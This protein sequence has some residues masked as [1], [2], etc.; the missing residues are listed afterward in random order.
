MICENCKK[1]HGGKYGSGR[2]CNNICARGF[3][4]KAKRGDINKKVSKTM[5][6]L[7]E[8]GLHFQPQPKNRIIKTCLECKTN[9]EDYISGKKKFC[10]KKC[11]NKSSIPCK[12]N[13]GLRKG[14][15]IG[16]KGWYKGYWCDSSWE[17]AWVIYHIE[18]KIDFERNKKGFDYVFNGKNHKYYPDFIKNNVY[19]EI[20]GY[21]TKQTEAKIKQFTKPIEILGK[22]E[23]KKII[24]FVINKYGKD[25]VNLYE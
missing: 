1:E 12:H 23:M 22:I 21:L 7:V 6:M 15:G 2:F 9:F 17:L 14:S 3:S 5:L 8:K 4:T 20:K 16:K 11:S 10:S 25:Y 19:Y 13:G 18:H 24:N